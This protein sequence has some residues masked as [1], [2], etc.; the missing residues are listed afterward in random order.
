MRLTVNDKEI[1]IFPGCVLYIRNSNYSSDIPEDKYITVTLKLHVNKKLS[2][3]EKQKV[4][5]YLE[6]KIKED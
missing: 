4:A 3:Y 1:H 6:D 5:E 2:N